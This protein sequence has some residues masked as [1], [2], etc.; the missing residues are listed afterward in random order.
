VVGFAGIIG[1]DGFELGDVLRANQ[2]RRVTELPSG[3]KELAFV[4]AGGLRADP[5]AMEVDLLCQA[6]KAA[7][8]R[9][10][11]IGLVRDRVLDAADRGPGVVFGVEG[12]SASRRR[13]SRRGPW[14]G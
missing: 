5:H 4:P 6:I 2:R 10:D 12:E 9:F 7:E 8:Q 13:S 1:L 14:K 11:P 3:M